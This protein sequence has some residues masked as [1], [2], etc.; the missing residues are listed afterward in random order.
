MT[1]VVSPACGVAMT[2]AILVLTLLG[3]WWIAKLDDRPED[4]A[5]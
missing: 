4:G 2:V 1:A 5:R 3:A